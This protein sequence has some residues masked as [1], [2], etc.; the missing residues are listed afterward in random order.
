MP[1]DAGPA[2]VGFGLLPCLTA[3]NCVITPGGLLLVPFLDVQPHSLLQATELAQPDSLLQATELAS[4]QA[5]SHTK[6]VVI[7]NITE[8]FKMLDTGDH[9]G[10]QSGAGGGGG[11]GRRR[12]R[13]PLPG[14]GAA[15]C[16]GRRSAGADL[17]QATIA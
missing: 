1:V 9:R 17:L 3:F 6:A 4:M 14:A 7:V 2:I 11:G 13:G 8:W 5:S 16:D 10:V 12:H 15:R